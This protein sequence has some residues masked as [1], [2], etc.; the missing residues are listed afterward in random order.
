MVTKIHKTPVGLQFLALQSRFSN[1]VHSP[2]A[3]EELLRDFVIASES[4]HLI[5][6]TLVVL[7]TIICQVPKPKC[8]LTKHKQMLGQ[9]FTRAP[10]CSI[11]QAKGKAKGKAKAKE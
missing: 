8:L 6:V 2:I 5:C 10:L 11:E 3:H 7:C 9:Y 4:H 1:W